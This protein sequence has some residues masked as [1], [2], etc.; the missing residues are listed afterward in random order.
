VTS[1][2]AKAFMDLHNSAPPLARRRALQLAAAFVAAPSL[3]LSR[4]AWAQGL[5]RMTE[6]PFYPAELPKDS[7]FDLTRVQGVATAAQGE[8]LDWRGVLVS[9]KGLPIAGARIEIWQC[10]AF[11]VYHHPRDS[12]KLDPG[13][14][15]FGA[16]QTSTDGHF[17][18][19]T[20]KPVPYTG[21]TPHIHVKIK[22]PQTGELTSQVF[23]A[24]DAAN[25]RDFLWR[26]LTRAQR[27]AAAMQLTR[28]GTGWSSEHKLVAGAV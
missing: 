8:L 28:S 23:L 18:F 1:I 9:D 17:A 21:R 10:N 11:G 13:F 12:G 27:D 4:Q 16:V 2:E 5:P 14:Q 25:E 24:G 7:D 19:R 6:G 20:I 15:G 3:L 26:Q 22:S